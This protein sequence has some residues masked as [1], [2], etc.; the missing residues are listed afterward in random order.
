MSISCCFN[1]QRVSAVIDV[2][3]D[4]GSDDDSNG[5]EAQ[6]LEFLKYIIVTP[7]DELKKN[8]EHHDAAVDV[9]KNLN[10]AFNAAAKPRGY[11]RLGN[12]KIEK[13]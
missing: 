12:V 1:F 3:S 6:S 4:A 11:K 8:V 5:G 9:K 2:E 7:P 10:K 13:E